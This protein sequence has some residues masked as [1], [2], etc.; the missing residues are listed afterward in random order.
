MTATGV[1]PNMVVHY[2]SADSILR[3]LSE[4]RGRFASESEYVEYLRALVTRFLHM[5]ERYAADAQS[6]KVIDYIIGGLLRLQGGMMDFR[7]DT[8]PADPDTS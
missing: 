8:S 2:R 1:S 4:A 7:T 6:L 5:K 3:T